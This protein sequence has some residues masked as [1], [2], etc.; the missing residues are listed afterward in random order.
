[1]IGGEEMDT[2]KVRLM[3]GAIL[4]C[5]LL[6]VFIVIIT[7]QNIRMFVG[8]TNTATGILQYTEYY[9]MNRRGYGIYVY[10]DGREYQIF[11]Y[12]GS[13]NYGIE[14][15]GVTED[16]KQL[17]QELEMRIGSIIQIEYVQSSENNRTVLQLT[18]D[19]KNYMNEDEARRDYIAHEKSGRNIW[20]MA[21][22]AIMIGCSVALIRMIPKRMV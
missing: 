10:V 8:E 4:L 15:S 6:E 11:R 21:L 14:G 7:N 17:Q 20:T 3:V 22:A 19:S 13:G 2:R 5:V 16:V 12:I 9:T 1:M 18:I